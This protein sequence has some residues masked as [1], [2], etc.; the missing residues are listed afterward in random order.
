MVNDFL[1]ANF[2]DIMDY[3]FTANVEKDFDDVA[4]GNKEWTSLIRQ[5]YNDFDPL[6]TRAM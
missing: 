4:E 6:V 2:P 5:F 3:N 1:T